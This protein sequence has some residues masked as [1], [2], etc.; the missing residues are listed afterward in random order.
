MYGVG[1]VGGGG[2]VG[3]AVFTSF[4]KHDLVV[5]Q[6]VHEARYH[7]GELDDLLYRHGDLLG[8][9]HPQVSVILG[10]TYTHR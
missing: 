3:G 7:L 8:D 9:L 1:G 2:G 6:Q 10:Q 4:Q 5:L